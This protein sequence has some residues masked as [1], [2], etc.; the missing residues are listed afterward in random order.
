ML[1]KQHIAQRD[2]AGADA[3]GKNIAVGFSMHYGAVELNI[4]SPDGSNE[5]WDHRVVPDASLR[6]LDQ[7]AQAAVY[8]YAPLRNQQVPASESLFPRN[9]LW[10]EMFCFQ[11][12]HV[13][14]HLVPT[15]TSFHH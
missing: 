7:Y 14:H 2:V 4:P 5:H 3:Y 11:Q 15:M 13:Y 6:S 1:A 12:Y 9:S 10:L 8:Q